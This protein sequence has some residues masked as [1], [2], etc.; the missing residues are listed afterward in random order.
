M[1][2]AIRSVTASPALK[3]DQ[4]IEVLKS[5][6]DSLQKV[7]EKSVQELKSTVS[8][9]STSTGNIASLQSAVDA[10]ST[11]VASS[12]AS[13]QSTTALLG[14]LVDKI[15]GVLDTWAAEKN[16]LT[17]TVTP[18]I[19]DLTAIA[20]DLKSRESALT[21][22]EHSY[23]AVSKSIIR[24]E[25]A[26]ASKSFASPI[27]YKRFEPL[28]SQGESSLAGS[29]AD[30]DNETAPQVN[31]P[32]PPAPAVPVKAPRASAGAS[33]SCRNQF[34]GALDAVKRAASDSVA[35][36]AKVCGY[37]FTVI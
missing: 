4:A 12:T 21:L 7:I 26:L 6:G 30:L 2:S 29:Q 16:E 27:Q 35:E 33:A 36:P 1:S 24:L 22:R 11:A 25:D 10:Q 5:V 8:T 34:D 31:S 3:A 23:D 32:P 15:T 17:T 37:T 28:P 19:A 9:L 13:A 20:D 14:T 18:T